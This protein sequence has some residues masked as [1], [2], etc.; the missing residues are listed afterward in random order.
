MFLSYTPLVLAILSGWAGMGALSGRRLDHD[1]PPLP[2]KN[3]ESVPSLSQIF[4]SGFL[5]GSSGSYPQLWYG[6]ELTRLPGCGGEYF[7][8]GA[9]FTLWVI[10]SV[11]WPLHL[12]IVG[13]CTLQVFLLVSG[14]AGSVACTQQWSRL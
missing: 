14:Q 6:C 13:L 12:I 7:V 9:G 5:V 11:C 4:Q 10:T 1:S 3:W 2:G 8:L